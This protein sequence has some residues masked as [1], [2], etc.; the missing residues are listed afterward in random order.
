MKMELV[1]LKAQ[2]RDRSSKGALNALRKSGSIPAVCYA[3]NREPIHVSVNAHEFENSWDVPGGF[4]TLYTLDVEGGKKVNVFVHDVQRDLISRRVTHIDFMLIEKDQ[5]VKVDVTVRLVGTAVG[6]KNEGGILSQRARKVRVSCLPSEIPSVYEH[7][8]TDVPANSIVY[9]KDLD[10]KGAELV[11]SPRT[12][13]FAI[14][15]GRLAK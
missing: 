3:K 7:D 4:K 1:T 2:S 6:V 9:L 8:I 14:S 10:L 5:P 11:S 13:L 15:K 12:V